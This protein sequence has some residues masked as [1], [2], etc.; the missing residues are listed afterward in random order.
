MN[1][2]PPGAKACVIPTLR[3]RDGQAAIEWLCKAFGFEAQ[4]VVPDS[5]G[6]IAHAQLT[7]G[8]GMIMLGS[9]ANND[10]HRLVKSP[11]ESGHPGSQSAYIVVADV[12]R[13]HGTAG[14]AGAEIVIALQDQAHGGRAYSCRDPEGHIWNFGSY[15]PWKP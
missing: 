9:A 5:G 15:D 11:L 6:A 4:L 7:F 10:F 3:Y 1:Q 12:D 14:A 13:H 2:V 8:N